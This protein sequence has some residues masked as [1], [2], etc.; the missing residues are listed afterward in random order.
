[1][2]EEAEEF[3]QIPPHQMYPGW[4]GVR[5][6]GLQLRLTDKQRMS[7]PFW[8]D[9]EIKID[10]TQGRPARDE[11]KVWCY[12]SCGTKEKWFFEDYN[13]VKSTDLGSHT[14]VMRRYYFENATTQLMFILRWPEE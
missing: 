1:M 4:G 9:R 11:R 8:V 7:A 10:M 2:F 5:S 14:V 6:R 13:M 12:D 3:V